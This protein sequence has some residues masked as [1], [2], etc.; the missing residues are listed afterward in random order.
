MIE[1]TVTLTADFSRCLARERR[2]GFWRLAGA[3]GVK[4]L[5]SLKKGGRRWRLVRS[6]IKPRRAVSTHSVA[7]RSRLRDGLSRPIL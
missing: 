4:R 5:C 6:A 3:K 1:P 2:A 7:Q